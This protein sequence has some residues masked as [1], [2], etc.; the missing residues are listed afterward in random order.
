MNS[1]LLSRWK[2][3]W[4]AL[5]SFVGV[6]IGMQLAVPGDFNYVLGALVVVA[7]IFVI[8]TINIIAKSLFDRKKGNG[9]NN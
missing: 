7:V 8:N 6:A 5:L 4:Y 2:F 1:L 3:S 9:I